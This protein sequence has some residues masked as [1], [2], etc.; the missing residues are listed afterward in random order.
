MNPPFDH[1]VNPMDPEPVPAD[2]ERWIEPGESLVSFRP[3]AE[4]QSNLVRKMITD[5][6]A[7][8]E[9]LRAQNAALMATHDGGYVPALKLLADIRTAVGDPKG[10]LMQDELVARCRELYEKSK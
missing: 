7:E 6:K 1:N 8:N 5:L 2:F 3:I 9:R 4:P 10:K